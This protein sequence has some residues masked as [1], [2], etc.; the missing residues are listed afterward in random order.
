M[1]DGKLKCDVVILVTD[2]ALFEF[3][4]KNHYVTIEY[5]LTAVLHYFDTII[6]V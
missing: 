2:S 1:Y 5:M 4:K 3:K 6:F